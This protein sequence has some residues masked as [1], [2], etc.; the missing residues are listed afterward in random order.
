MSMSG[1]QEQEHEIPDSLSIPITTRGSEITC[2][3]TS[4]GM[5]HFVVLIV[6]GDKTSFSEDCPATLELAV[7]RQQP[8]V[9]FVDVFHALIEIAEKNQCPQDDDWCTLLLNSAQDENSRKLQIDFVAA[10][11]ENIH[12][13]MGL[14]V[15]VVP[16]DK[17]FSNS[18]WPL[19]SVQATLL[20]SSFDHFIW[21]SFPPMGRI[22]GSSGGPCGEFTWPKDSAIRAILCKNREEL[23]FV[24][25]PDYVPS[26]LQL[27]DEFVISNTES[28]IPRSWKSMATD[29]RI[30]LPKMMEL[31]NRVA[32]N[33]PPGTEEMIGRKTKFRLYAT[34]GQKRD[35]Q[36]KFDVVTDRVIR[37]L[38]LYFEE[39]I[40]PNIFEALQY[41]GLRRHLLSVETSDGWSRSMGCIRETEIR[42]SLTQGNR[43]ELGFDFLQRNFLHLVDVFKKATEQ[44]EAQ[45]DFT[46]ACGNV[47]RDMVIEGTPYKVLV[48]CTRN[49]VYFFLICMYADV[50][51][52]DM[53][54]SST[55]TFS[56]G[57]KPG[58][59]HFFPIESASDK[60]FSN[61]YS[62]DKPSVEYIQ[63]LNVLLQNAL[64]TQTSA[65]VSDKFDAV[66]TLHFYLC[67][68]TP[69]LRGGGSIAEWISAA[70]MRTVGL[71]FHGWNTEVWNH[72]VTSGIDYFVENYPSF[73]HM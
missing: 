64:L 72:A 65:N 54:D 56:V 47:E 27:S 55:F 17:A 30:L 52:K 39:D 60:W 43:F 15:F 2:Y 40:N 38:T 16:T 66:A 45:K 68:K 59:D 34:Y 70:V 62:D 69:H 49:G 41:A 63:E 3:Y 51:G 48:T 53:T 71:P 12:F 26:K 57:Y 46:K 33:D 67:R 11:E 6:Q 7:R 28:L 14:L 4:N 24:L 8:N 5:Q 25:Q 18:Q 23:E 31:E 50:F 36:W 32:E 35:T 13:D 20:N 10:V 58:D 61:Q 73:V 19:N 9:I 37:V 1:E 22:Y 42:T 44:E 29:P 21:S